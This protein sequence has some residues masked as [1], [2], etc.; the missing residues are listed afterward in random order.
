MTIFAGER[1]A[2]EIPAYLLAADVLV[3]PRSRGTN[4]PLKIYQYLRSGKPIVATRLLTHTQVLERRDGDPDRRVGRASLRDGIL[5]ALDDPAR[6]GGDRTARARSWPRRSTATRP[7]SSGRA[8]PARRCVRRAAGRRGQGRRVSERGRDHYSYTVYADPETARTFDDRR[9][10]GPIGEL[11]ADDAGAACWPDFV[12][13]HPGPARS[14]TSA[15]APAARRCCWPRG[16]AKVTGVD[17]SERDA[18]G[19]ARSGRAR[20]GARRSRSARRRP[21]ARVSAIARSTSRSACAC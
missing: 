14:S 18:G 11:V 10:G 13:T 3:S 5:A 21:R 8:R 1:P 7:I 2:D 16:G 19:R 17:A 20:R 12:G 9:F 6:G 15:P 4:T